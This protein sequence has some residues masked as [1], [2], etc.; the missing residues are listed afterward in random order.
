[1]ML[2]IKMIIVIAVLIIIIA[3]NLPTFQELPLILIFF[4]F[5]CE[6]C[7]KL[8]ILLPASLHFNETKSAKR[9]QHRAG[10]IFHT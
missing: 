10:A 5:L 8:E 1:M 4:V 7:T 9:E 3:V 6:L 2:I